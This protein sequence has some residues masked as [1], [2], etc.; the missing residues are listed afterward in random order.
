MVKLENIKSKITC[1]QNQN[2]KW[3]DEQLYQESRRIVIAQI[4]H[5]TYNEFLPLLV[6][7]ETWQKY[8]MV[9]LKFK[10]CI[11]Q[12]QK[13]D[14]IPITPKAVLAEDTYDLKAD[15]TVMNSYAAAVGQVILFLSLIL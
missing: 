2:R 6:G 3:T 9:Y 13:S 12:L 5:I 7:R 10:I 15:A 8:G 1:F 11:S 4:Q 14:D